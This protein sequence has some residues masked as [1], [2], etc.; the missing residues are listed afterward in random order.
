MKFLESK[1]L[2][3]F[4]S[5][6]N[7]KRG[8]CKKCGASFFFKR[9]KSKYISISAGMLKASGHQIN[10]EKYLKKIY[11]L[12]KSIKFKINNLNE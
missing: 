1:G 8:F 9:N 11:K 6:L 10:K 12:S 5:S 4:K 7:A 3:W 2:K